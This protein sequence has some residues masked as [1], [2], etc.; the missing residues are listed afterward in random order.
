MSP[1]LSLCR[2]RGR[3]LSAPVLPTLLLIL[4]LLL[5]L[6]LRLRPSVLRDWPFGPW[7]RA[8]PDRPVALLRL[9]LLLLLA[10]APAGRWTT[11]LSSIRGYHAG[12][13]AL[14]AIAPP[15]KHLRG[16]RKLEKAMK[17][18]N[19]S[20]TVAR[21]VST[22]PLATLP[23]LHS[24]VREQLAPAAAAGD[25]RLPRRTFKTTWGRAESRS[26]C[27]NT[28]CTHGDHDG[29]HPRPS[30]EGTLGFC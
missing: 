27:R 29:K 24:H 28:R 25:R 22:W 10:P 5:L 16:K 6:L 21:S 1:L 9:L 3:K 17:M 11:S 19:S 7:A 20:M 2:L 15:H 14:A 8:R 30:R 26:G 18:Q 12:G 23:K 13:V 4:L